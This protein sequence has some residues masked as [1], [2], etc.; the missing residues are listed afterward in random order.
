ME[1]L[2]NLVTSL[3]FTWIKYYRKFPFG[4]SVYRSET[5]QRSCINKV[6]SFL[7]N[8]TGILATYKVKYLPQEWL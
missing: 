4:W 3:N 6:I 8:A 5:P 2:V 1:R 7:I